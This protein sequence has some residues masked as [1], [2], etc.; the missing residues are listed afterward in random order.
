MLWAF[1]GEEALIPMLVLVGFVAGVFAILSMISSRNSRAQERLT[2]LSRPASLTEIED[3]KLKK[4]RFQG[5]VEAAKSF[6]KPLMPQSEKES[7]ELRQ[8]LAHAGFR[9]ESAVAVYLGMR[10]FTFLLFSVV[11][12]VIFLPGEGLNSKSLR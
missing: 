5:V 8:K 12:A 2:R 3:P 1:I 6:A 9:S 7:S 11:A 10:F 4:E